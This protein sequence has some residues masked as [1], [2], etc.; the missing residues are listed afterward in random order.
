M[1]ASKIVAYQAWLMI[2]VAFFSML[3]SKY[4]FCDDIA[5]CL[6]FIWFYLAGR[7]ITQFAAMLIIINRHEVEK[8]R[9][10]SV[11]A[12][13]ILGSVTIVIFECLPRLWAELDFDPEKSVIILGPLLIFGIFFVGSVHL[14]I[15]GLEDSEYWRNINEER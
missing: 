12:N 13:G 1:K 6:G 7:S 3:G 15:G 4:N 14:E 11:K 10:K 9:W 8:K 5:R 2:F